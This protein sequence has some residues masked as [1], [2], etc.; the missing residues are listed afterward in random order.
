MV[1]SGEKFKGWER[2]WNWKTK[3]RRQSQG[4]VKSGRMEYRGSL[5]MDLQ[6]S[7]ILAAESECEHGC[8][9]AGI[10]LYLGSPD[11]DLLWGSES[12]KLVSVNNRGVKE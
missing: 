6:I 3:S 11:P 5:Y 4:S 12:M 9:C 2:I 1:S 8:I 10:L 7:D